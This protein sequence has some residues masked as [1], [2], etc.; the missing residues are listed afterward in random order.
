MAAAFMVIILLMFKST[1]SLNVDLLP[2]FFFFYL[3]CWTKKKK[4]KK[5]KKKRQAGEMENGRK[6]ENGR[7]EG[8]GPN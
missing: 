2:L 6:W 1:E 3:N 4:K 8:M 5:K 7:K